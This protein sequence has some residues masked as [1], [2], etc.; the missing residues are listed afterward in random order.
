MSDA[1]YQE[2]NGIFDPSIKPIMDLWGFDGDN[3]DIP[4]KESIDSAL[5]FVSFENGLHFETFSL[6]DSS[7]LVVKNTPEF[8]LDFNAIAQGYSVDLLLEFIIHIQITLR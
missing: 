7:Y 3:N 8:Q 6:T 1:I 4:K 2:T 5:Q